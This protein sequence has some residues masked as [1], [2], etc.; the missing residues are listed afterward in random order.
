M[1]YR[2]N[3]VSTGLG[4]HQALLSTLSPRRLAGKLEIYASRRLQ[5]V[6]ETHH[7]TPYNIPFIPQ[8]IK[9]TY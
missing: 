5:Y 3:R 2:V 9:T 6:D 1:A 8:M 4:F 7:F